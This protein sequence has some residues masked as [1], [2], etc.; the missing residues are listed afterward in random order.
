MTIY[1][2]QYAYSDDTDARDVH[3]PAHREFLSGLAEE[4][5]LLA[6]GPYAGDGPDGALLLVRVGEGAE[7]LELLREDPFQQQG[8]VEQVDV[9]EWTPVLGS[10]LEALTG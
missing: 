7:A 2:V 8:L 1:A 6:S 9:R 4:G 10:A 5:V 3:R